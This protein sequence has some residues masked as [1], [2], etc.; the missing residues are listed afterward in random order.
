MCSRPRNCLARPRLPTQSKNGREKPEGFYRKDLTNE[1]ISQKRGEDI[2]SF[3]LPWLTAE[4]CRI[5][6]AD[7]PTTLPSRQM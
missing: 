6:S 5:C 7:N 4:S 1:D 3:Y 2:S